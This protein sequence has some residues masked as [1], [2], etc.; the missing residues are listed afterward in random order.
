MSVKIFLMSCIQSVILL[1]NCLKTVVLFS[2]KTVCS[3]A[4][5]VLFDSEYL[6]RQVGIDP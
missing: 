4:Q 3:Q 1:K 5:V 2:E 6:G